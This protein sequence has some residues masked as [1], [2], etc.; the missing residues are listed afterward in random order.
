M[1]SYTLRYGLTYEQWVEEK[2]KRIRSCLQMFYASNAPVDLQILA[3]QTYRERLWRTSKL[4]W[5][6]IKGAFT[7][8][9]PS[10]FIKNFLTYLIA[11]LAADGYIVCGWLVEAHERARASDPTVEASRARIY[12]A[13][14]RGRVVE[15]GDSARASEPSLEARPQPIKIVRQLSRT[16]V[17]IREAARA[18]DLA[19]GVEAAA[20]PPPAK[21]TYARRVLK[22][23]PLEYL[24]ELCTWKDA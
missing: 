4:L 15:V 12:S 11:R 1:S 21:A 18:S 9:K 6:P 19:R 24:R 8:L 16:Y 17:E 23:P 3:E 5:M 2:A 10:P 13:G 14:M 7:D 20:G 22:V